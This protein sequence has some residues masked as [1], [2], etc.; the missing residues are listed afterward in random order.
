M[1]IGWL[2]VKLTPYA[3]LLAFFKNL[4]GGDLEAAKVFQIRMATSI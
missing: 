1:R 2:K 4:Y 3:H